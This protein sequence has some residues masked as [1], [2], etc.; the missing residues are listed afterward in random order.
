MTHEQH[1]DATVRRFHVLDQPLCGGDITRLRR[2]HFDSWHLLPRN[3]KSRGIGASDDYPRA[4][5]SKHVAVAA[6]MPVV[7][8]VI[9]AILLL[10]LPVPSA[11]RCLGRRRS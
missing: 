10:S 5:C 7:S 6:P 3:L 2:D 8:P 9:R 11:L 4:L 1:V